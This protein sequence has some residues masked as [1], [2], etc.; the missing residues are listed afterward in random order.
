MGSESKLA[1]CGTLCY[2]TESKQNNFI[3]I[4]NITAGTLYA[5]YQSGWQTEEMVEFTDVDFTELYNVTA[6]A[7]H[8]ENLAV[9]ESTDPALL[10]SLH[11]SLHGFFE[12]AGEACP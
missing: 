6:D 7:W 9:L 11:D 8:M 4:R 3:A 10:S 1:L 12:C 5:E 2:P